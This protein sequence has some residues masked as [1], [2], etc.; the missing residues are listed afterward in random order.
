[1]TGARTKG[2]ST[3]GKPPQG[4][5]EAFYCLEVPVSYDVP[6]IVSQFDQHVMRLYCKDGQVIPSYVI[7][8]GLAG[9]YGEVVAASNYATSKGRR[10]YLLELGDVAWYAVAG[11]HSVGSTFQRWM[12]GCQTKPLP[13]PCDLSVLVGDV[14]DRI[15]K[16]YWHNKPADGAVL[17]VLYFNILVQLGLRAHGA[18]SDL[19]EVLQMNIDKLNARWKDGFKPEAAR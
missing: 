7:A 6:E 15:K 4:W 13:L 9:E 12:S 1:M 19:T 16:D 3:A 17:A 18:E 5:G 2:P 14:C 10:E 8:L 11:L